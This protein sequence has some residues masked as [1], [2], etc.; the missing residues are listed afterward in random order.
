M[1]PQFVAER[2]LRGIPCIDERTDPHGIDLWT[3]CEPSFNSVTV[4]LCHATSPSAGDEDAKLGIFTSTATQ[5]S[6]RFDGLA[7]KRIHHGIK[8]I[9]R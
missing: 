9:V 5:Q 6:R 2:Y 8:S 4:F 1:K 3:G 7:D